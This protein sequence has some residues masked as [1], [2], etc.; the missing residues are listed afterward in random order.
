MEE[1]VIKISIYLIVAI[2]LGYVFG[3]LITKLLIEDKLKK[4]SMNLE[5]KEIKDSKEK[6]TKCELEKDTLTSTNNK[7]LLENRKQK[8]KLHQIQQQKDEL[9]EKIQGYEH[10]IE[11]FIEERENMIKQLKTTTLK[12]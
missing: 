11:A 6:L 7:I 10:E 5:S 12:S 2:I 1:I 9:Q 8:L 3:W 4:S